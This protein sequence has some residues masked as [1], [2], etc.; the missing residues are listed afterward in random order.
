MKEQ[1]KLVFFVKIH[2]LLHYN[3]ALYWNEKL[4]HVTA[5]WL[6]RRSLSSIILPSPA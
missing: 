1:T 5:Q 4:H 6:L 3:T 2:A